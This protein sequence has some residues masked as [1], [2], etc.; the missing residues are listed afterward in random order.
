MSEPFIGEVRAV[1][2]NFAMKGWAFCNGQLLSITQNQALFAILGTTYGG[3]GI[4]TFCLPDLRGRTPV[5]TGNG[6]QFGEVGGEATHT[7]LPTEIPAHNHWL[8]ASSADGAADAANRVPAAAKMYVAPGGALTPM[9]TSMLA[10]AGSSQ[11]HSNMQPYLA[12]NF[13]IALTGIFPS[14]N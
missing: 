9:D 10:P 13:V 3:D 4:T 12:V 8:S 2:F 14:H 6:T 11:P 7:L 5:G 1:G